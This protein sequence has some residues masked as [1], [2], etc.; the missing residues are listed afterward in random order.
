MAPVESVPL[1]GV[2]AELCL[3]AVVKAI[4][5]KPITARPTV[6]VSTELRNDLFITL[7]FLE[8]AS[9]WEAGAGGGDKRS[10]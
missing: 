5:T 6:P 10:F 4:A 9:L 1:D 2:E 3:V 7:S 8:K